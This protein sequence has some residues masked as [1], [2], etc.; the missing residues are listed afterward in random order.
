VKRHLAP[1]ELRSFGLSFAVAIVVFFGLLLPWLFGAGWPLW[2]WLAATTLALAAL[3]APRS[4]APVYRLW[5]PLALA[6][7]WLN[8]RLILGLVFFLV[9]LPFGLA[10][11]L[12]GRLQYSAAL[13]TDA[14]SYREKADGVHDPEHYERPF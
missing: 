5:R 2:P 9:L 3:L 4:L 13:D 7:G 6:V 8:T 1:H 10:A 12:V 14:T 11:R